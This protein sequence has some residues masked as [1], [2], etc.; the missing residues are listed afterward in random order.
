MPR[1]APF[2]RFALLLCPLMG[3]ATSPDD[4]LEHNKQ[5]VRVQHEQV[6]SKGDLDLIEELY[7]P[8]FVCHFLVGPDW[9]GRNGVREQVHAHRA[10]FPD[11]HESVEQIIAEGDF[12]TTRFTST[13]THR[14]E[15]Q[16]IPPTGVR[17]TVREVAIY[18]LSNGRIAEQWGFP[19]IMGLR[20]Q[21]EAA[22]HPRPAPPR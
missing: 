19:D 5:V 10:S 17:V 13:G 14:G 18:R 2:L 8:D 9:V 6:W 21:L 12:V 20:E 11:W 15:F 1:E 22:S 7:T 4:F 16:G 3:C